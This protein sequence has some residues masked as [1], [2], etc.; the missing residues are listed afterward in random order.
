M[1]TLEL[2]ESYE[3]SPVAMAAVQAHANSARPGGWEVGG[4]LL[5][6]GNR[7][8]TYEPLENV[9]TEPGWF[10]PAEWPHLP[11]ITTH[12]HPGEW[13]GP[14]TGDVAWMRHWVRPLGIYAPR[15]ASLIIW[16]LDLTTESGVRP[17]PVAVEP[18]P[19]SRPRPPRRPGR[20]G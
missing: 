14:S 1:A 19:R 7:L 4:Q 10:Q 20:R 16:K 17:V 18:R 8:L 13:T 5:A 6:N 12:T 9:A 2:T 15:N 3:I 11:W